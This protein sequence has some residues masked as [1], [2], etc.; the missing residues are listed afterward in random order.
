[1]NEAKLKGIFVDAFKE[2]E[3][4]ALEKIFYIH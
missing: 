4:D 3:K 2:L 1:M